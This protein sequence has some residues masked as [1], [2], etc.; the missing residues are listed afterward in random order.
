MPKQAKP[1]PTYLKGTKHV[2]IPVHRV[3]DVLKM[4]DDHGHTK[5]FRRLAKAKG[6]VMGMHPKTVNFVKDFVAKNEMH[7]HPVGKQV[8]N[9]GGTYDCTS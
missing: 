3:V 5:K 6:V 2:P 9:S 1:K 8:V 4:I 7:E